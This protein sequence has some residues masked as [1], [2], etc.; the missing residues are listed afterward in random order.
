MGASFL[1][2]H[3]CSDGG[4]NYGAPRALGFEARSYP[5]TTGIA[6]LALH[7]IDSSEVRKACALAQVQLAN[8]RSSEAESWLR[9][10]LLAHR[11]LPLDA[12]PPVRTP[13]TVQNSALASLAS[14]AE[15]GVNIFLD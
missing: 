6:L 7:G 5:E 1:I 4:W 14:A 8:C 10:G 11:Q 13:R 2:R 15:H 3:A 12:P 9:L